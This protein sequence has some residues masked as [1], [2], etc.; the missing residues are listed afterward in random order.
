MSFEKDFLQNAIKRFKNY[1]DLG[2]K[3][4]AQLK[5]ED[6]FFQPTSES[7]SIAIVIQ[8]LYGNMMSR[9]TNF[10]TEDGEKHWRKRDEEFEVM[11]CSKQDLLSFWN[12]GWNCLLTTLESLEEGDLQKTIYIRTEPLVVMDAILRQL[13]HYPYHVGQIV[14][15]GRLIHND[16][17]KSLSIPKAKGASK[18]YN[19]SIKQGIHKQP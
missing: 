17:W 18:A 12:D 1:K 3:T 5:E 9:W 15:I 6:F 13:A 14:Y 8:H 4:F 10:L 16:D 11:N 7:N 19:E 2:D